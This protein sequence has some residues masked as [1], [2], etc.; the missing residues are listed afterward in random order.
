MISTTRGR[1]SEKPEVKCQFWDRKVNR[2]KTYLISTGSR[3]F[4]KP[5]LPPTLN[6]WK[7]KLKFRKK[8]YH[9]CWDQWSSLCV[10]ITRLNKD[11][12]YTSTKYNLLKKSIKCVRLKMAW[13]VLK[14]LLKLH[15]QSEQ[16][17]S[18]LSSSSSLERMGKKA[19][20]LKSDVYI[21]FI[22]AQTL[23]W[24]RLQSQSIM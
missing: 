9:Q 17:E 22:W 20:K 24:T 11:G 3:N 14:C 19:T 10:I 13:M 1:S 21:R 12:L 7:S 23:I 2:N 6:C 18:E 5:F 8:I 15:H 16:C 4:W